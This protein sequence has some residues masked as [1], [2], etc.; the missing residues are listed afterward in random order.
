MEM[1]PVVKAK[2]LILQCRGY[3]RLKKHTAAIKKGIECIEIADQLSQPDQ[4]L[5]KMEAALE[6]WRAQ[7]ILQQDDDA[8]IFQ[9]KYVEFVKHY[10]SRLPEDDQYKTWIRFIVSNQTNLPVPAA[11]FLLE[12]AKGLE[13]VKQKNYKSSILH[14]ARAAEFAKEG[15]K[16]L[17]ITTFKDLVFLHIELKEYTEATQYSDKIIEVAKDINSKKEEYRGYIL[18]G[19]IYGMYMGEYQSSLLAFNEALRISNDCIEISSR[20]SFYLE[21]VQSFNYYM[22]NDLQAAVLHARKAVELFT[23][24]NKYP[25]LDILQDLAVWH[26]DLKNFC[27]AI[28]YSDKV[29][30]VAKDINDKGWES[31]G[32]KL[33]GGIELATF[34]FVALEIERS[35]DFSKKDDLQA[36][37]LDILNNLADLHSNLKN[38][39]EEIQYS[40]KVIEVAKGI[41]D[42]G[43]ESHGYLMKGVFYG[44]YM[45]EYQSSFTAL[46]EA[47]RIS[48]ENDCI[49]IASLASFYLERVQSLDFSKKNNTEAAILHA[50]KA[51][52]FVKEEN[53]YLLLDTLKILAD[54]HLNLKNYS[55]A[56]QYSEKVIEVAKGINDKGR[57]SHGYLMKGVFYGIYMG[58]YQSSLTA[59]KEALRISNENDCIEIASFASFYLERVQSLDSSKKNDLQ[60]AVLHARKAVELFTVENKYPLLDTLKDLVDLHLNVKNYPEAIQYSEKVIEVAKGINDK[61]W[62]SHGYM[63][64]GDAYGHSGDFDSCCLALNKAFSISK[65]SNDDKEVIRNH[66]MA[67]NIANKKGIKYFAL[68]S[69]KV[70]QYL[71]HENKSLLMETL[72][73]LIPLYCELNQYSEA[74]QLADNILKLASDD[75]QDECW[76]FKGYFKRG[77][78]YLHLGDHAAALLS[79]EE[80]LRNAKKSKI[81][82]LELNQ[83]FSLQEVC[84]FHLKQYQEYPKNCENLPPLGHLTILTEVLQVLGDELLNEELDLSSS[85]ELMD[86]LL[87]LEK[88]DQFDLNGFIREIV[89]LWKDPHSIFICWCLLSSLDM[90]IYNKV[91]QSPMLLTFYLKIAPDEMK[92]LLENTNG[93]TNLFENICSAITS[94]KNQY[95]QDVSLPL[96]L[97]LNLLLSNF[98]LE[99]IEMCEK[100]QTLSLTTL[101]G[102]VRSLT[103]EDHKISLIQQYVGTYKARFKLLIE[104]KRYGDALWVAERCRAKELKFQ[105]LHREIEE[106]DINY[107]DI[108]SYILDRKCAIIF[109]IWCFKDLFIYSIQKGKSDQGKD[110]A[111]LKLHCQIKSKTHLDSLIR[112]VWSQ[113]SRCSMQQQPPVSRTADNEDDKHEVYCCSMVRAGPPSENDCQNFS[114]V[115]SEED[116]VENPY[117]E[118]YELLIQTLGD[119]KAEE[120]VII[121]EG[122]L[123]L[124]PFPALQH[125]TTK[126]FLSQDKKLRS[127]PSMTTLLSH[128][129]FPENYY[130]RSGSLIIGNPIVD[131][132]EGMEP[133]PG[134]KKEAE[135]IARIIDGVMPLI[136]PRATKS[137]VLE[138]LFDVCIAHFACHIK[139][140]PSAI[141]L[142][143][144][145]SPQQGDDDSYLLKPEDIMEK[146]IHARLVVLS[147]CNSGLGKICAEGVVGIA[148]A[149]LAA[150]AAAVLVSLWRV[151]DYSTCEFMT[152]FYTYFLDWDVRRSASESLHLTISYMRAK[153]PH[154]PM[155]WSGFYLMG[156]DVTIDRESLSVLRTQREPP[157]SRSREPCE[158]DE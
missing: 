154:E 68:N 7:E 26:F 25:L 122:L 73:D 89:E 93:I 32:Y 75:T 31:R 114:D 44:I 10:A 138:R 60:A 98:S 149:F 40:E 104:R 8:T 151:N 106:K 62:E 21:R 135:A 157:A 134:A 87:L 29:I 11:S 137:A 72:E 155:K 41:N 102:T 118:L 55:E 82:E 120:L 49:E 52:E 127:S 125:P 158:C 51:V 46:K 85:C 90:S 95:C 78:V 71:Q 47:L 109:Y 38:Y 76:N 88:D 126:R 12:K 152:I 99:Q 14:N 24:E 132:I 142:S 37:V 79:F 74:L 77:V 148:R 27:E 53:K 103:N 140:D 105:L 83:V 80:A 15:N 153:Y 17:L 117:Q 42:K 133:L 113:M 150:G 92:M 33:K 39:S 69:E 97:T 5:I 50:K 141:V 16:H 123:Y 34:A 64:K 145:G 23:L 101:E 20:A 116:S 139:L 63:M 35:M 6:V 28:Q 54:L 57:E 146:D 147:G 61:G 86:E 2:H 121:P 124:L 43:C 59:L 3:N 94:Q 81:C 144:E 131:Q 143:P 30:E 56:I 110:K 45:G 18:K 1:D 13:F 156:D 58:E 112:D 36:A 9:G 65:Q 96:L 107:S 100:L 119:I 108:E 22:K 136:G 19:A 129:T 4:D 84:Q 48:N 111:V 128:Q 66:F 130:A 115:N 67:R 70:V 91:L